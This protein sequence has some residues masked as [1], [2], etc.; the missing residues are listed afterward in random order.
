MSLAF[1]IFALSVLSVSGI[2]LGW[3]AAGW[4]NVGLWL[5]LPLALASVW[6]AAILLWA[7]I[8]FFV[9]GVIDR[10]I[11]QSDSVPEDAC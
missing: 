8:L 6:A 3:L 5:T 9:D 7:A 10:R 4:L 1:E 2:V 11:R